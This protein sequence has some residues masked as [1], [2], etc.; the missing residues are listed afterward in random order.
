MKVA[1]VKMVADQII[2]LRWLKRLASQPVAGVAT[3]VATMLK[4]MTH[5]TS[6][7]VADM[8]PCN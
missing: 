5:D 6:S 2:N 3:A 8:A 1:M 4:V 7:W